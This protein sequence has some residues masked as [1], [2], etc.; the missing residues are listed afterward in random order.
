MKEMKTLTINGVRYD[1]KDDGALRFDQAENLTNAQK[2][3]ARQ[4]MG[5]ASAKDQKNIESLFEIRYSPNLLNLETVETGYLGNSGL[6]DSSATNYITTDFIACTPGDVIRHQFDY[7]GNRYDNEVKP[8]YNSM[9][10]VCAYDADKNFISPKD[11]NPK[12][13]L[14]P[15]LW[16][17]SER[18]FIETVK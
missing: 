2:N 17:L 9:T 10:V 14:D 12:R 8:G 16:I 11:I 5:A 3:Q 13:V 15:L 7:L 6:V 4:N 1:V 18:K